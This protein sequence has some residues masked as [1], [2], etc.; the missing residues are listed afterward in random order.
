M[1]D[2]FAPFIGSTVALVSSLSTLAEIEAWL[3]LTSLA[4]GVLAG[5]LGCISGIILIVKNL[6]K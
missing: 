2:H 1:N 5:V 4:V 6:R 3:K